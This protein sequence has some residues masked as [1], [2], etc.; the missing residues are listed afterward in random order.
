LGPKQQ[1]IWI[2]CFPKR[3]PLRL[4]RALQT[5]EASNTAGDLVQRV[6]P[7]LRPR[8]FAASTKSNEHAYSSL[9]ATDDDLKQKTEE[10]T[11]PEDWLLTSYTTLWVDGWAAGVL[12]CVL[13][14]AALVCLVATLQ[15]FNGYAVTDIPL[16]VSI[17]TLVAGFAAVIKSS[18]LLPVAEGM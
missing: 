8:S 5:Y 11:E 18:L 17:N 14:I 10:E 3:I 15:C 4:Y 7:L 2:A 1:L 16:N 9:N 12:S 13:S 6:S